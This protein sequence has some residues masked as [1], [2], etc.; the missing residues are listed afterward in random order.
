MTATAFEALMSK[1]NAPYGQYACAADLAAHIADPAIGGEYFAQVWSF[2]TEVP[3]DAQIAFAAHH[4]V[5]EEELVKAAKKL[6]YETGAPLPL[7]A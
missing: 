6:A 7:A 5:S 3:L 1:V 4:N 2:Y